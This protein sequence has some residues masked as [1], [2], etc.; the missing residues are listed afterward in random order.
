MSAFVGVRRAVSAAFSGVKAFARVHVPTSVRLVFVV[1]TVFLVALAA[2]DG[3]DVARRGE[4]FRVLFTYVVLGSLFGL[5]HLWL[6][7][8]SRIAVASTLFVFALVVILN[9]A[10]FE[11]AG[12][13]DYVFFFE[14]ARE[15]ATP[16]GRHIV[17]S[18]VKAFEVLS[19]LLLPLAAGAVLVKYPSPSFP[20]S[21]RARRVVSFSLL[22]VLVFLPALGLTTHEALSTFVVSGIRFHVTQREAEASA[23]VAFPLVYDATPSREARAIAASD[24]PRPH[25]ILLFLE[26]WSGI[27]QGRLRTNGQ[28]VT[29]VFDAR[30]REGLSF[31]HFYGNSMQSSRGHFATLCSLI[32]VYRGKEFTDLLETRLHCLPQ[33]LR[34]VGYRTIAR[35]ATDAPHFEHATEFFRHIGFD[36]VTFES[37]EERGKNPLIWGSGLQDDAFYRTFFA[38]IDERLSRFPGQ[39][40]FAV[41]INASNHYP[42]CEGPNFVP[43][44]EFPTRYGRDFVGSLHEQDAWLSVFFQELERRPALND[45]IV[46]LVGDHSFPADEHGVHFNGLSSYEEVFRTGFA[47]FWRGHLPPSRVADRTAS[48]IDIAPTVT[49][50]LQLG[51]PTHFEGHSLVA[52]DPKPVVAPLVQPYDGVRLVAVRYPYKLET[53]M[54]SRQEHLFDLETDP[55]EQN[56]RLEDPTLAPE[57]AR[58]RSTTT[59]ILWSQTIVRSNRV[60]PPSR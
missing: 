57:L 42:F 50:L 37:P 6:G 43:A 7:A 34:D 12:S 54:S 39:P 55:D 28:P 27:W 10:R 20:L 48:Q 21:R 17:A 49:D 19:L 4:V 13:F 31:D 23:G 45:A 29:P 2:T 24:A 41:G 25:V 35:S 47:M 26:S 59:R 16:L 58:L 22:G 32:P 51:G 9:F 8:R 38:E 56:D 44:E 15:L 40:L 18:Q 33:A 11:T 5:L 14:N 52:Q 60:W 53:H 1:Q 36:E 46:I 30:R 3:Y